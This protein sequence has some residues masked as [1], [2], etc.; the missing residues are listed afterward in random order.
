MRFS[1]ITTSLS[2][3]YINAILDLTEKMESNGCTE[4]EIMKAIQQLY[5]IYSGNKNMIDIKCF[6]G[7]HIRVI[8]NR[9]EIEVEELD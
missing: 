8:K 6:N 9:F 3:S 1:N 5:N 2:D 4:Q 7:T